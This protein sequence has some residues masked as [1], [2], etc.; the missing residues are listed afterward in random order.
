VL[1]SLAEAN[2]DIRRGSNRPSAPAAQPLLLI[3]L[4][5]EMT[6]KDR[7]GSSVLPR[8]RKTRALLAVLALAAPKPV[9]R[10]ALTSLLWSQREKEQARAS[11]RQATHE[12]TEALGPV[13][14]SL[15]T[16]DR[17]HLALS[18]EGLWVDATNLPLA[19]AGRP[20]FLNA[21]QPTFLEG[22]GGLDPA[23]DRWIA[24]EYDKLLDLARAIAEQLLDDAASPDAVQETAEQLLRIDDAHE[25]GWRALI[26]AHVAR[27]DRGAALAAFERC[28]AALT[29]R[30]QLRPTPEIEAAIA[31]V[32]KPPG[33]PARQQLIPPASVFAPATADRNT[34]RMGVVPFR[35]LD[36]KEDELPVALAEEITAALSRFRWFSCVACMPWM[37]TP[38]MT[39][40]GASGA[41]A[42]GELGLDCL[43]DGSIQRSAGRVRIIA[44]LLDMRAGGE[45]IWASRFDCDAT[46][47]LALQDQI[48]GQIAARL[49]STLLLREGE[50]AAANPAASSSAA[51]LV[52]RAIPAIFRLE[53]RAFA[54]AGALLEQALASEP[55]YAP[56]HAWWAYWHLLQ[57]GQGWAPDPMA[58]AYQAGELASRAVTLDPGDARALTF[59]GH[60][61]GFLKQPQEACALHERAIEINPSLALAW[62]FS[63]LAHSY[64]GEHEQGIRRI[65]QAHRLSPYD[66]H[67][68]FFDMALTIP[69]FLSGEHTTAMEIGRRAIELNPGF[70]SSY[71]GYLAALGHLGKLDEAAGI[72][73]RLLVLEP[74][75]TLRSARERSPMVRRQDLS[76]YLEG[77]R[78]AGLPD[79]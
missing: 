11:L 15:L 49:D 62:C 73:D 58:A 10:A 61:R 36:A 76:H 17:N 51:T 31:G 19:V 8:N 60:V 14:R 45:V 7:T 2:L 70:S 47:T 46:D 77:L 79:S 42:F 30:G 52:L 5:G 21:F 65:E 67:A 59:A 43:L 44:R 55:G 66:P 40:A 57:V 13:C 75:F 74:G 48:A 22:L 27:G 25:V 78:R 64:I 9:L 41:P 68:F 38:G 34:F 63:G 1:N 23:F 50:R 3:R 18:A 39:A 24:A 28:R 72:R 35:T 37:P 56:A 33:S 26:S 12:L 71:K 20:D 69:Y 54:D 32:M 6:A 53:Q 16:A 4:F 29:R